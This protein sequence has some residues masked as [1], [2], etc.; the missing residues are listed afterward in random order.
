MYDGS[1]ARAVSIGD[2]GALNHEIPAELL[3]LW[4]D[5]DL[6]WLDFNNRNKFILVIS[7]S[8]F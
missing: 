5:R 4:I 1:D 2:D 3:D 8:Y 6:S 7:Y